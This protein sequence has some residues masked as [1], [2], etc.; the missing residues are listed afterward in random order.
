MKKKKFTACC[1]N[2]GW[3]GTKFQIIIGLETDSCPKC[4]QD[5]IIMFSRSQ[6]HTPSEISVQFAHYLRNG[7]T[8]IEYCEKSIEQHYDYFIENVLNS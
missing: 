6:T 5:D 3:K 7:L 8:N 2:C 1:N 4:S